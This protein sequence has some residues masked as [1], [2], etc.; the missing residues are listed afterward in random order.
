MIK[1]CQIRVPLCVT[2]FVGPMWRVSFPSYKFL[3]H[4]SNFYLVYY[5]FQNEHEGLYLLWLIIAKKRSV[6]HHIL[7]ANPSNQFDAAAKI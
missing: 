7:E 5:V 1:R 3:M 6:S 2:H 4:A